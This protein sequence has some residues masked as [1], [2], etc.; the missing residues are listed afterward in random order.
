MSKRNIQPEIPICNIPLIF[1]NIDNYSVI[2]QII[3]IDSDVQNYEIFS[4]SVNENTLSIIYS[5]YSNRNELT[6][7]IN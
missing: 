2:N 6:S 7:F 4:D 1:K 5:K 3:L